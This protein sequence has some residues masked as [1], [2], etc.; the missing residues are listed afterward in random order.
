[1]SITRQFVYVEEEGDG[2]GEDDVPDEATRSDTML[3]SSRADHTIQMNINSIRLSFRRT[4]GSYLQREKGAL[5][6]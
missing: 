6:K 4:P 2:E 5:G 1:M 3:E